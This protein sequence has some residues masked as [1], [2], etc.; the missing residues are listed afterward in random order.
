MLPLFNCKNGETISI[1][2]SKYHASYPSKITDV[3][4]K[5][6]VEY[7]DDPLLDEYRANLEENVYNMVDVS[8]LYEV[9]LKKG[10]LV[11]DDIKWVS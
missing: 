5:V 9:I 6:Q 4:E 2:G 1:Q 7:I 10:G 11:E 8:I 3:Y